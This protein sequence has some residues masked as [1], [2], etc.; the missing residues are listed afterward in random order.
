M[1]VNRSL[2][3]QAASE[4]VLTGAAAATAAGLGASTTIEAGSIGSVAVLTPVAAFL[5][6]EVENDLGRRF[7][8]RSANTRGRGQFRPEARQLIVALGTSVAAEFGGRSHV[9]TI[10]SGRIYRDR[11]GNKAEAS[12]R[13]QGRHMHISHPIA[14]AVDSVANGDTPQSRNHAVWLLGG[15]ITV[16]HEDVHAL[17]PPTRRKYLTGLLEMKDVRRIVGYYSGGSS[18]IKD[19]FVDLVTLCHARPI[20]ERAGALAVAP[21][22][23]DLLGNPKP[24]FRKLRSGY[25]P[26]VRFCEKLERVL[27]PET[28][29]RVGEFADVIA[30]RYGNDPIAGIL[31]GIGEKQGWR[32]PGDH[33]GK[34]A[35][36]D[37]EREIAL[38]LLDGVERMGDIAAHQKF[39]AATDAA[40]Q[41][42]DKTGN[43][44]RQILRNQRQVATPNV[45]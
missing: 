39:R 35:R 4:L 15:L 34:P 28:P 41:V 21:Y 40:K 17:V 9:R 45:A 20:L 16:I 25:E 7:W 8:V 11:A 33:A 27:A 32:S 18:P 12:F 43:A 44:V 42:G 26:Y 22:L 30:S 10:G 13:W 6:R 19:G 38:A 23:A 29:W 2:S 1:P 3:R 14:D 31:I 24:G 37:V 5:R 36:E